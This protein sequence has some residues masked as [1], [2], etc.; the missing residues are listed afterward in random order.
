MKHTCEQD[1]VNTN[2]KIAFNS[3]SSVHRVSV[4]NRNLHRDPAILSRGS[5]YWQHESE[6]PIKTLEEECMD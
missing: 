3:S 1:V 2:F 4:T 6:R 5:A